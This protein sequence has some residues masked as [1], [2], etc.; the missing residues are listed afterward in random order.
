MLLILTLIACICN[1]LLFQISENID[2]FNIHKTIL[3]FVISKSILQMLQT[4]SILEI[5]CFGFLKC[6]SLSDSK[7]HFRNSVFRFFKCRLQIPPSRVYVDRQFEWQSGLETGCG[8]W[9][10][11][12]LDTKQWLRNTCVVVGHSSWSNVILRV[13]L[14][15]VSPHVNILRCCVKSSQAIHTHNV[16]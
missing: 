3:N 10:S 11:V 5:Q 6:P 7:K 4:K 15:F 2:F 1:E 16:S 8:S 13:L 12:C 14:H 9:L